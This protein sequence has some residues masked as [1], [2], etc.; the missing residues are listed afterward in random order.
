MEEARLVLGEV[1]KSAGLRQR[2]IYRLS[3]KGV[4]TLKAW[5]FSPPDRDT[6]AHRM[7]EVLL[8]FTFYEPLL[9]PAA[10][11]VHL[12]H[13]KDSLRAHVAHLA[14]HIRNRGGR[15]STSGKLALENRLYTYKAHYQWAVHAHATYLLASRKGT[16]AE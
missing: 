12:E 5:I 14:R 13:L 9:G 16:Q 8:R 7:D 10:T 1:E 6:L 2:K 4:A 3:P 15:L 11:A